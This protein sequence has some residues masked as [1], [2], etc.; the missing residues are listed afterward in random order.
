MD[1]V[2][3][4]DIED[5]FPWDESGKKVHVS[6]KLVINDFKV[7]NETEGMNYIEWKELEEVFN[8]KQHEDFLEWINGQ[9]TYIEGVYKHDLE[10][11]LRNN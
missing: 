6:S 7:I 1:K 3:K 5:I 11:F 2:V 8:Q 10:R 4:Q 9:T